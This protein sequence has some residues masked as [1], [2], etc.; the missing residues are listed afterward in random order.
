MAYG[1]FKLQILLSFNDTVIIQYEI[2]SHFEISDTLS[3]EEGLAFAFAFTSYD[4][5][6]D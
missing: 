2:D 4:A 1:L 6:E 3:S 5:S